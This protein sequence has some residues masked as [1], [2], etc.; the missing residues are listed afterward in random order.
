MEVELMAITPADEI[1]A[2]E[3]QIDGAK[4]SSSEID[5]LTRQLATELREL[6]HETVGIITDQ[7]QEHSVTATTPIATQGAV[8]MSLRKNIL[9]RILDLLQTGSLGR[10]K[11][12]FIV[13]GPNE[14]EFDGTVPRAPEFVEAWLNALTAAKR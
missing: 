8:A 2:I 10:A 7:A 14:I 5:D 6:P 9:P 1:I 13:K 11:R 3:I 4:I 12:G